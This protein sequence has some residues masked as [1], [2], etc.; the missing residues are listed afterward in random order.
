MFSIPTLRS[1]MPAR[2]ISVFLLCAAAAAS[3]QIS[4]PEP[5][6]V[7]TSPI[8]VGVSA[9]A[10]PQHGSEFERS[11][12]STLDAVFGASNI[13]V[14]QYSVAELV[15]AVRAGEVDIFLSSAGA[16]RRLV[17]EGARPLATTVAPGLEDPNHNEGSA[18]VVRA[19]DP[20]TLPELEG[21]TVA[22]N[23]PHGFSGWQIALGEIAA[24]GRNPDHFFSKAFFFNKS[25]SMK[26]VAQAVAD[27]TVDAGVLRLC[28]YESL[29]ETDPLLAGRLRVIAP[30]RPVEGQVACRHST[31]LYPAQGISVM[32]A[33]TP[34]E[35]RRLL[36]ALL[37]M[38]P[39]PDGRAWSIATDFHAVDLLLKSL[40]I[41]PYAYLRQWTIQ[42]FVEAYW[43]AMLL[44]VLAVLAL[45]LHSRRA[46]VL[47]RRR[48]CELA[49]AHAREDVQMKRIEQLQRAGA[50]GQLSNLIAHEVH[51]P[52]AAIRLYAEGLARQASDPVSTPERIRSVALRI[53]AQAER[54]GAIVDRVRDYARQRDPVMRPLGVPELIE[55]LQNT[56][57]KLGAAVS[58]NIAPEARDAWVK[59]SLIE[60]E[61]AVVNLLRNAREAAKTARV[62]EIRLFV[63]APDEEVRFTVED[64]GP[65]LSEARLASLSTPVTSQKPDGL[66]LGL[67]IV[68]H[69]VDRHGGKLSF[70][71]RQ[72][73]EHP[74]ITGLRAV[75]SIPKW[76]AESDQALC[77]VDATA[78][79]TNSTAPGDD[80]AHR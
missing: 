57:T 20:R 15:K 40:R 21:A 77:S 6:A 51:Q 73:A 22:A 66:G 12:F 62:P 44:S 31:R 3:A 52:L 37:T 43:P 18:V 74:E 55:H 45:M 67:S 25:A 42:R 19:D 28:A 46:N 78:S 16:A 71:V 34:E 35:S 79:H 47:V 69:L 7:R 53:A 59:G 27:G 8:R 56:Y 38:A 58:I 30:V 10:L 11:T 2:L 13:V 41:G 76:H 65:G 4:S 23:L 60:L 75:I 63:D 17:N 39:T 14:R 26:D 70:S 48:E 54:A 33:V 29:Q 9:F 80:H 32:P 49:E 64:N 24:L 36:V 72:T 61:L 5:P 68:K 1:V 50:V